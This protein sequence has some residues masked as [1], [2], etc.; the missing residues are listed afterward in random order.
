V[1]TKDGQERDTGDT[2]YEG[3]L[4]GSH[5]DKEGARWDFSGKDDLHFVVG[6][7]D[8]HRGGR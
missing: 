2:L 7:E 5:P 3:N 4:K 6:G 8:T 1:H